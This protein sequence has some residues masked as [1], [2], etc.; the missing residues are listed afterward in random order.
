MKSNGRAG[1]GGGGAKWGAKRGFPH[2]VEFAL[3]V[4]LDIAQDSSLRQ[5]LTSSRAETSKNV[6]CHKLGPN[7]P[8]SGP[9]WYFVL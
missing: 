3:L 4:F 9:K 5:Y 1:G 6:L 8:K 2:F 7:R